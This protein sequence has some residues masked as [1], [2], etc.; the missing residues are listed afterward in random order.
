[1]LL[2]VTHMAIKNSSLHIVIRLQSLTS[3]TVCR[4]YVYF[5]SVIWQLKYMGYGYLP[6]TDER[7]PSVTGRGGGCLIACLLRSIKSR[8][9]LITPFF[10][11]T[12]NILDTP[13]ECLIEKTPHFFP[14]PLNLLFSQLLHRR[15]HGFMIPCLNT[16]LLQEPHVGT[17]LSRMLPYPHRNRKICLENF[18]R[19]STVGFYP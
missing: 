5:I 7:G 17:D 11:L 2:N 9:K 14:N 18:E 10:L 3:S 1:M 4:V 6:L 16:N 13:V 8:N 19:G 12:G 15:V